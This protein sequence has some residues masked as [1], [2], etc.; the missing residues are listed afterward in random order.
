VKDK[1]LIQILRDILRKNLTSEAGSAILKQMGRSQS[2]LEEKMVTV[3]VYNKSEG[4][5][6]TWSL[7]DKPVDEFQ[8]AAHEYELAFETMKAYD[9]DEYDVSITFGEISADAMNGV[10]ISPFFEFI[11]SQAPVD[12]VLSGTKCEYVGEA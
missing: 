12:N 7:L 4:S 1:E 8:F 11:S 5:D 3:S 9:S 6:D 2:N 10:Q